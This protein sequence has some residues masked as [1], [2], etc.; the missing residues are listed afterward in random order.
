MTA[1][2]QT[3][4]I[5]G[6]RTGIILIHGTGGS[7]SDLHQIAN[8]LSRAGYTVLCPHLPN[9]SSALSICE[10]GLS[11]LHAT[12]DT[13]IAGGLATGAHLSLMLA[14]KNPNKV[15]GLALL[16]PAVWPT[17]APWYAR[18]FTSGLSREIRRC[19]P[20]I[21]QPSLIVHSRNDEKA[22][23]TTACLQHNLTGT[24]EVLVLDARHPQDLAIERTADF[25]DR[26]AR[27]I[28]KPSQGVTLQLTPAKATPFRFPFFQAAAA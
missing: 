13:V 1:N 10:A 9:H 20:A 8:G 23:N 15:N 11:E 17:N 3:Y 14:A 4:R 25:I 7:P 12:C 18:P 27:K 6:G 28:T 16:A 22:S 21:N 2:D 5:P 24:V 19:L 26:V